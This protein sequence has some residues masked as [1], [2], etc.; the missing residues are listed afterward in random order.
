MISEQPPVR[1]ALESWISAAVLL[2]DSGSIIYANSAW[3]RFMRENGG[4]ELACG[5]GVN[6]LKVCSNAQGEGAQ[7]ASSVARGI[8]EVLAGRRAWYETDYPC[9]SPEEHRWFRLRVEPFVDE[10]GSRV[11]ILHSP[12][13]GSFL[14][15]EPH[16]LRGTRLETVLDALPL[17]TVIV[18]A[19]RTVVDY[20][21]D[22]MARLLGFARPEELQTSLWTLFARD[23]SQEKSLLKNG[24]STGEERVTLLT[25][26]GHPVEVIRTA[27]PVQFHGERGLLLCFMRL[28][29]D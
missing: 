23:P 24:R 6:Y 5:V 3:R 26:Q 28:G 25:R 11:L 14:E 13:V 27:T 22:A 9:H 29:A 15:R 4:S 20:A 8:Q 19:E 1:D 18:S 10:G 12:V 2:N 21:N 17:A 16:G 7:V